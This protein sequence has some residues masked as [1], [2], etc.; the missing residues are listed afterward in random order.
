MIKLYTDT[1]A[2]LPLSLTLQHNIT[3]VPFS[4]SVNSIE[5]TYSDKTDFDGKAF[6]DAMR[7]GAK[8][9]TSMIGVGTFIDFFTESLE[10]GH[11]VLYI[12]MSGGISGTANAA[13]IAVK[14]LREKYPNANISAIDTCAASLG[15]GLLVLEA[16]KLISQEKTFAE[17]EKRI[18]QRKSTMCQYFTVD[19]LE[20]LK[21][22]GRISSAVALV[23]T[24]LNIKPLLTGDENGKIIMCGKVRGRKQA[25]T[26][27]AE[28]YDQLV[29]DKKEDIAIAHADC[30]SDAD[31]LISRLR[32]VGFQGE[33]LSA[34]Y[35]PVTGSHV[36]PGAVALFFQGKNK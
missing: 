8:V 2:N 31:Y 3:V 1:S 27:L 14:E 6:Y 15:E 11:D 26:S 25:L 9:R 22:G 4:Y 32:E 16:A 19:N 18:L 28:K 7:N 36:G 30:E 29:L 10:L 35:E 5:V 13:S 33:C 34:C 23:G 21:R 17:I 24:I 20:Y 12:G